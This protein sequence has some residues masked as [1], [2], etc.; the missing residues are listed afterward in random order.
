MGQQFAQSINQFFQSE[1]GGSRASREFP[2]HL[3]ELTLT[4]DGLFLWLLV[5][6]ECPGPLIRFQQ[7]SK[8][9]LAVRAHD[10]IRVDSEIHRELANC[11]KLISGG[12]R[13]GR[14]PG[15]H[16]VDELTVH[17]DAGVQIEGEFEPAILG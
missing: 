8:F 9:Q 5:A 13:P 10:G 12:Q 6:D 14:N 1:S 3:A 15:S 4:V 11:R 2:H 17:G 7:T 16:L